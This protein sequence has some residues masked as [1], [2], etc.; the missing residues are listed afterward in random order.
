ME[1]REESLFYI[2]LPRD[3]PLRLFYCPPLA[4]RAPVIVTDHFC[5]IRQTVESIC[6]RSYL[7]AQTMKFNS[8]KQAIYFTKLLVSYGPQDEIQLFNC[9]R[10]FVCR[11]M[12]GKSTHYYTSNL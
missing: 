5:N 7:R 9:K 4:W 1:G 10:S 8:S 6:H 3:A 2:L 11:K 12:E